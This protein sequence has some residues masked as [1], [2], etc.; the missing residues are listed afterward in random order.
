VEHEPSW[1]TPYH[2]PGPAEDRPVTKY[3]GEAKR[4]AVVPP[5]SERQKLGAGL[6][7]PI[8]QIQPKT[9]ALVHRS[10]QQLTTTPARP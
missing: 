6:R 8:A 10:A 3:Y 1:S 9:P 2:R 4:Y 5:R 7:P